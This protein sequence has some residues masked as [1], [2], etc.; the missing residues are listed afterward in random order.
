ML[1]IYNRLQELHFSELMNVY[2]EGNREKAEENADPT[3]GLLEV[4]QEFYQYLRQVFFAT[5]GALY[6]VWEEN[7]RYCS[8][9]RLEPYKDGLLLEALETA[10]EFRQKGYAGKLV[11]AVSDLLAEKR[12]YAH[13]SKTNTASLK[14]HAACGFQR[15]LDYAAYVDGSVNH[16]ACTLMRERRD[17][18][19]G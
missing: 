5:P 17:I 11:S 8:A 13:V 7:E 4:E 9:L 1:I 19:G 6:A 10:P 16:R 2:M 15:V 3:L 14:T 18:C 12:I